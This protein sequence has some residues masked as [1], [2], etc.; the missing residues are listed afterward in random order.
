MLVILFAVHIPVFLQTRLFLPRVFMMYL[1]AGLAF[2]FYIAKFPEV[3]LP[4]RWLPMLPIIFSAAVIFYFFMAGLT[5]LEAPISGGTFSSSSA[6]P[7]VSC[8]TLTLWNVNF[9][10]YTTGVALSQYRATGGCDQVS[11]CIRNTSQKKI[12]FFR[13]LPILPPPPSPQ[14]GQVVQHF[15]KNDVYRVLQS[16]V[17]VITT[18]M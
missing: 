3:V 12:D 13:A 10:G 4:G 18:M 9:P 5:S 7:I 15:S 16:Q 2:L 11:S 6:L 17:T 1:L 8:F 14:F